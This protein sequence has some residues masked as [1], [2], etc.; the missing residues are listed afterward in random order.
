MANQLVVVAATTKLR[1][2]DAAS[3]MEAKGED[4][5]L[6]QPAPPVGTCDLLG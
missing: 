6:S 5:N 4:F 2:P 1:Q 3:E